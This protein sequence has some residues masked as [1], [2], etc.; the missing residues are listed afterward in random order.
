MAEKEY[1]RLPGRGVRR[2]GIARMGR[3]RLW[4]GRDHLLQ[5]DSQ[6]FAEEYKRFFFRDIQAVIIR[7]TANG[8]IT[9]IVLAGLA[10]LPLVAALGL[11]LE[12]GFGDGAAIAW[13]II[14]GVIS[15]FLLANTLMGPTCLCHMK[16]AVQTEELPSL[17]RIRRARKVLARVRPLIAEAQGELAPGEIAARAAQPAMSQTQTQPNPGV[18]SEPGGGFNS[19]FE[20]PAGQT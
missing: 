16:T 2:Q 9:N 8:M 15:G 12:S 13:W 7:K 3:T 6:S 20:P 5:V 10:T 1:R 18:S 11:S 4:L 19:P 14:G 17:R